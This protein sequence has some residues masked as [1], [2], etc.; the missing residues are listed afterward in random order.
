MEFVAVDMPEANRFVIHIMAAVAEQDGEAISKRTKSALAAA[1]A[2]G[3]PALVWRDHPDTY[4]RAVRKAKAVNSRAWTKI[5][6]MPN[7][8]SVD[9][10]EGPL[11]EFGDWK[12][13]VRI[14]ADDGLI[15]MHARLTKNLRADAEWSSY[16]DFVEQLMADRG[17]V[18]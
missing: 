1:K 13:K 3:T 10:R 17:I 5:K 9:D 12:E 7:K 4:R 16:L 6:H 14:L 11:P 2:R 8:L 18:I 15:T